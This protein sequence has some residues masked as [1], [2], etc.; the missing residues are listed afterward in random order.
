MLSILYCAT[1]AWQLGL[2]PVPAAHRTS[3]A[4]RAPAV[5]MQLFAKVKEINEANKMKMVKKEA[6]K[7]RPV[8]LPPAMVEIVERT[9]KKE[10]WN[11]QKKVMEKTER[12]KRELEVLWGALLL[13]YKKQ[14]VAEQ[15][16]RDNPQILNPSYTFCNTV[17]ASKATLVEM[18]GEQPQTPHTV[19]CH[20]VHPS[21][22]CTAE[23]VHRVWPR[24]GGHAGGDEAQPGR[25]AVRPHPRHHRTRRDTHL[26]QHP[27]ARL[28]DPRGVARCPKIT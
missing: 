5:S 17:L 15:A 1:A 28:Q 24:R 4:A 2:Q 26:R 18:M 19:P 23:S 16:V 10:R 21:A 3:P 7:A 9:Q 14:A 6:P 8:R 27:R 20:T 22:R 11:P 13:V 12:P 25:A